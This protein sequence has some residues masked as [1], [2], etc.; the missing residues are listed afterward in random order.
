[1]TYA[2]LEGKF[3]TFL[4]VLSHLLGRCFTP[5]VNKRKAFC[6]VIQ[7]FGSNQGKRLVRSRVLTAFLSDWID[8]TVGAAI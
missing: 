1:M 8:D 4:D 3:L 6:N 5:N 7:S 2:D